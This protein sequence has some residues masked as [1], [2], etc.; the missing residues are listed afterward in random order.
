MRGIQLDYELK[1][2]ASSRFNQ[3]MFGRISSRKKH[4]NVYA[5]YIPGVLDEVPHHRIFEGRVFI[6]TQKDIDLDT[7]KDIDFDPVMNYCSKFE[8]SSTDKADEDL[9]MKTSRERWIFHAKE[10]GVKIDWK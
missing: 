10:R 3:K 7:Q 8:I 1:K 2:G 9:F 5:Y 4:D 6:D